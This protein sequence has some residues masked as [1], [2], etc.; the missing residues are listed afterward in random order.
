MKKMVAVDQKPFSYWGRFCSNVLLLLLFDSVALLFALWFSRLCLYWLRGVPISVERGLLIIP[1]WWVGSLLLRVTPGWGEAATEQ[2]RRTVVLISGIYGLVLAAMFIIRGPSPR[3]AVVFSYLLSL[4][5]VPLFR[6]AVKRGLIH[7]QQWGLPTVVYGTSRSAEYAIHAMRDEPGLGY[8]VVGVFDDEVPPGADVGG[9]PVLGRLVD[10]TPAAAVAV[11]AVPASAP[12]GVVNRMLTGPLA[13]YRRVVLLPDILEIPTLWVRP[14]DY[15]GVLGL[16]VS[17]NLLNPL[18][19]AF[20]TALDLTLTLLALPLWFPLVALISF[21]IW[22]EDPYA[23]ILLA[24]RRIGRQGRPFR[25][26]KFRSMVPDA[27]RVLRD[28]L[29]KDAALRAEWEADHKLK[30][31]PR[32]TWLGRWLRL[33]SLDELPQLF[34]VLAGQMTLVGPRPLPEYHQ[35]S[36]SDVTRSLREQVR[37]GITGLWQVSGR[38][39]SGTAGMERWDAYYVRNWSIWLDVVILVRTLKEVFSGRGAY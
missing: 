21:L 30:H 28:C 27:E 3:I 32:V 16:E 11:W 7:R 29:A 14:M 19:R 9:T 36:L 13:C 15:L 22:L 12:A 35:A 26:I 8:Q 5:L 18:A 2:L 38:A 25:L 10:H 4:L 1:A 37:P 17:N 33:T 39:A 6:Q 20:K 34:N 31:D 23:P 24:Q